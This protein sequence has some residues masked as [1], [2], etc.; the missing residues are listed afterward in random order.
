M[1]IKYKNSIVFTL[2]GL[3]FWI[4]P[5]FYIFYGCSYGNWICGMFAGFLWLFI[6]IPISIV[7]IFIGLIQLY[8]TQPIN[9]FRT[10]IYGLIGSVLLFLLLFP[11]WQ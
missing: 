9:S 3:V 10:I 5:Y 4:M 2:I 7:F 1:N 6:F 11:F 8:K